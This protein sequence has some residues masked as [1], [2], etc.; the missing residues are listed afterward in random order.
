VE[1]PGTVPG[2]DR[3]DPDAPTPWA[4][5]H[6]DPLRLLRECE[7]AALE[8]EGIAMF[9]GIHDA[10]PSARPRSHEGDAEEAER[11]R[12]LYEQY[13]AGLAPGRDERRPSPD[14]TGGAWS[15]IEVLLVLSEHHL[16]APVVPAERGA[17]R[18]GPVT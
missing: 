5:A 14:P 8:R 16:R 9:V 12:V 18:P 7:R 4:P 6:P 2:M 15:L 17:A 1:Q 10:R 11:L 3:N 13:V